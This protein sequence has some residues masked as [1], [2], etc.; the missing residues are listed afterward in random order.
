MDLPSKDKMV[1]SAGR[2]IT[3]SLFL[4]L[5]Y[6][7]AAVYTLKEEDYEYNGRVYP[8]IK[9]LYIECADPTEYAFAVE[10][11][12][13][14]KHWQRIADNKAIKKF[15][16]EWREE[17]EVKLRSQGVRQVMRAASLPGGVQAAKWLA[18]RGWSTRGAGR[19]TKAEIER[20]KAIHEKVSDEYSADIYRLNKG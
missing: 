9:K 18:D 13:N 3:Q 17:L 20:E 6:S 10:Y 11:F 19:P 4:E 12:L 8:S 14:W 2:P 16:D 1:D 15:I 7:D 5:G